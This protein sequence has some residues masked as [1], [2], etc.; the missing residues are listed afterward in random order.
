MGGKREGRPAPRQREQQQDAGTY[1]GA[2]YAAAPCR[3]FALRME[4]GSVAAGRG[5][6]CTQEVRDSLEETC[7]RGRRKRI[8]PVWV[9][10]GE[11]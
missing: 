3:G 11:S 6:P 2:V 9:H 8:T 7:V 1:G 4:Y 10:Q 5:A